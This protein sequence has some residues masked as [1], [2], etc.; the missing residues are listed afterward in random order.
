LRALLSYRDRT[1]SALT[2][3]LSSSS[4]DGFI[5]LIYDGFKENAQKVK[6]IDDRFTFSPTYILIMLNSRVHVHY[7]VIIL[8]NSIYS[9]GIMSAYQP[10]YAQ[11]KRQRP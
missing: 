6:D 5:F 2:A 4:L 10:C 1:P 9:H 7:S 11:I 3:G 8:G